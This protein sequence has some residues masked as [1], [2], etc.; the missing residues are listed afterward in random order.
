MGRW[1]LALA[2]ITIP[3]DLW[4]GAEDTGHSPDNG[5]FLATRIP[6]AHRHVVPEAGGSLLWTHAE[7]ILVRLLER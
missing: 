6:G 1:P 3:V 4:Y 2:E 7:P 5:A